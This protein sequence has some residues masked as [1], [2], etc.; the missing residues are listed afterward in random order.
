MDPGNYKTITIRHVM[1]KS[2]ALV[3]DG[4]VSATVET[5]GLGATGQASFKMNHLTLD[6]VLNTQRHH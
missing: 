5:F 4:E 2:Y 6:H 3:L 1:S